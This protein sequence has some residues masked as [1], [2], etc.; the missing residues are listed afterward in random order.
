LQK[1]IDAVLSKPENR[2]LDLGGK[3]TTAEMGEAVAKAIKGG[4]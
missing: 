3:A 2:T 4:K 1:A